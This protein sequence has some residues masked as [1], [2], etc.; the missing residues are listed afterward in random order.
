LSGSA[1]VGVVDV[2]VAVEDR[3]RVAGDDDFRLVTADEPGDFLAQEYGWLQFAIGLAQEDGLFY[4]EDG[5]GG[6]L[7]L[8]ADGGKSR[9]VIGGMGMG[10]FEPAEPSVIMTVMISHPV[11]AHFARVPATVKSWSSGW[12]WMDIAILGIN[13]LSLLISFIL[14]NLPV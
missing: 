7:F 9:L 3:L 12:A 5:V 14:S 4:A 13:S 8:F 6:A 10:S 1:V 2:A 11:A